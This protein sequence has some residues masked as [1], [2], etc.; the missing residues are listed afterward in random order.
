MTCLPGQA[1]L[2]MGFCLQVVDEGFIALYM[3]FFSRVI[4]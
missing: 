1:G 3:N 4:T 2:F